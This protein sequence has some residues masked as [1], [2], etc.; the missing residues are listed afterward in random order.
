MT[1]NV[2][3]IH[4]PRPSATKDVIIPTKA[5]MKNLSN[6]CGKPARKYTNDENIRLN[7]IWNGNRDSVRATK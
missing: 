6:S 5:N 2:A 7:M 4:K 3:P 1:L